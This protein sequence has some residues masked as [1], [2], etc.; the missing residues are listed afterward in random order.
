MTLK[1]AINQLQELK[2]AEDM[3]I[4][5]KPCLEEIIHTIQTDAQEISHEQMSDLISKRIAIETFLKATADGDKAEWCIGVI[6]SIPSWS[7]V[8]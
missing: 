6:R 7:E 8:E 2:K 3:P 5:Y 1:G 4:Y